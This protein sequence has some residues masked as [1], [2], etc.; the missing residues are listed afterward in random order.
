MSALHFAARYGHD[1][2]AE[3]LMA[4][5]DADPSECDD[6]GLSA[7]AHASENGHAL[8]FAV[9]QDPVQARVDAAALAAVKAGESNNLNLLAACKLG[10]LDWAKKLLKAGADANFQEKAVSLKPLPSFF[11][12]FLSLTISFSLF[13]IPFSPSLLSP[14]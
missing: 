9:L 11:S 3:M 6:R 2:I 1:Q 4:T 7:L 12:P 8:T 13:N 10:D 14:T 5:C